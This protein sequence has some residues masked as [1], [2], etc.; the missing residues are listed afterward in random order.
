MNSLASS[1]TASNLE[2]TSDR[3]WQKSLDHCQREFFATSSHRILVN[4]F[5]AEFMSWNQNRNFYLKISNETQQLLA[6]RNLNKGHAHRHYRVTAS[7]QDWTST[8]NIS[9][10]IPT[11]SYQLIWARWWPNKENIWK[12]VK[13][14]GYFLSAILYI[15]HYKPVSVVHSFLVP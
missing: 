4:K 11:A 8:I 6:I 3:R 7:A 12:E 5:R 9:T 14:D 10:G 1:P 13:Q 2:I 15:V